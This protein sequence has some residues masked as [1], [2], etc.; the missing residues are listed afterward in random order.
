M[1]PGAIRPRSSR[2]IARAP[3]SVAAV[4]TSAAVATSLCRSTIFDTTAVNFIASSM[5]CGAVSVPSAMVTP[6]RR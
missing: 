1:A 5:L 3:P 2:P 4:K 6:A